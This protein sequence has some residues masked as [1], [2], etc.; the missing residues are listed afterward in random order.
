MVEIGYSQKSAGDEFKL[1][2]YV[3]YLNV[4]PLYSVQF[5]KPEE[6]G[7]KCDLKYFKVY[8]LNSEINPFK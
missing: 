5:V 2:I 3:C 1:E 7:Q 6:K 8:F 4:G